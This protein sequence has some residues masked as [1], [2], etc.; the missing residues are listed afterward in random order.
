MLE[1]AMITQL[2]LK[3]C[4]DR[5]AWL[6]S[7]LEEILMSNKNVSGYVLL[8]ELYLFLS[9]HFYLFFFLFVFL[10]VPDS[11]SNKAEHSVEFGSLARGKGAQSRRTA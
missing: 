5:V 11:I 1:K 6:E 3:K 9:L 7:Q 8:F 4:H 10:S 2:N